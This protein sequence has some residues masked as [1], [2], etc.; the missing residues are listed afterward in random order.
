MDHGRQELRQCLLLRIDGLAGGG[1]KGRRRMLAHHAAGDDDSTF[2]HRLK[3]W[4]QTPAERGR[5]L[6]LALAVCISI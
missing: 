2:D 6:V 5:P 1:Q 3:F 4:V